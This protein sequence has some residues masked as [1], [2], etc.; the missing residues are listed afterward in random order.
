M[1]RS[2][3]QGAG[4]IRSCLPEQGTGDG[5]NR[6]FPLWPKIIREEG[7]EEL[8]GRKRETMVSPVPRPPSPCA[9]DLADFE[10]F[11]IHVTEWRGEPDRSDLATFLRA[12]PG[13]TVRD[14]KGKGPSVPLDAERWE[15]PWSKLKPDEVR[16]EAVKWLARELPQNVREAAARDPALIWN[17]LARKYRVRLDTDPRPGGKVPKRTT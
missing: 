15:A 6:V 4:G 1:R 3:S 10:A 9:A 17:P 7:E 5:L 16:S 14:W 2:D 8:F 12:N 13:L 11:V